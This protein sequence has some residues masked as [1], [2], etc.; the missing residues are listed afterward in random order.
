MSTYISINEL[1]VGIDFGKNTIPVGRLAIRDY[2][3]Y[4]EY[5]TDFI[6]TGLEISPIKLPLGP[7]LQVF[8]YQPFEGL[9]GVFNDSLPDGW[10]RL[11]FDRYIRSQNLL[12][13]DFSSLDRLTHVGATGLGAL[14]YEPDYSMKDTE[15]DTIDLDILSQHTQEILDGAADEVLEELINLNGSSA[16]ARPKA[17]IGLDTKKNHIISGKHDLGPDHEHWLVKFANSSDGSDAGAIEYVYALMAKEAGVDMMPV[18][19]FNA[20]KGSGYFATQRFDREGDKRLH[21]HTASGLLHSN[22]RTPS[23]DYEDLIALTGALTKDVREIEK[24]FRLAVFNVLSHNRDDHGKNF[25]FVMGENGEWKLSPAYDL[26]FSSGPRGQ[27]STMVMG[28]GQS[29]SIGHLL[30]LGEEASLKESKV[31]EIIDQTK[32]A[33]GYWETLADEHGVTKTNIKLIKSRIGTI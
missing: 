19:L 24:M 18:H 16:G 25:S 9:P 21:M 17:L 5:D 27:Q 30:K 14:V 33:L 12:P 7:G 4:F 32:H 20:A 6:K 3:T 8:D 29:P 10:G 26:T 11:L 28:E 22:F 2:K 23:L 13:D 1:R 15:K 31:N